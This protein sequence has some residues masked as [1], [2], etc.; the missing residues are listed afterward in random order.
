MIIM[1]CI[2]SCAVILVP[3]IQL[4][5]LLDLVMVKGRQEDSQGMGGTFLAVAQILL[6]LDLVV[7]VVDL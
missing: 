7:V 5:L 1:C 6:L 2:H 3:Q 4:I